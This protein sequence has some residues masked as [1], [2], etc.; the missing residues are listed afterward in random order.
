M[1]DKNHG[2][3]LLEELPHLHCATMIGPGKEGHYQEALRHAEALIA[4]RDA[5]VARADQAEADLRALRAVECDVIL[6][7][8]AWKERAERARG[9]ISY[10][11]KYEC[12]P[13]AGQCKT[14]RVPT[15]L[16]DEPSDDPQGIPSGAPTGGSGTG[17]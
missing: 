11:C 14:C 4:E 8:A 1:S 12:R 3:A 6:D 15:A 2:A 9:E 5:A 13:H 16:A 7:L 10:Y 17:V